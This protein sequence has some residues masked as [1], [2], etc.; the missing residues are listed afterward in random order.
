MH[1]WNNDERMMIACC[2]DGTRPV[3]F[4][5]ER[6][7]I[8]ETKEEKQCLAKQNIK[9]TADDAYTGLAKAKLIAIGQVFRF[10][11]ECCYLH[12]LSAHR[13]YKILQIQASF[14]I[15]ILSDTKSYQRWT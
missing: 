12:P 11:M 2:N 13:M 3:I 15:L 6:I 1:N 4:K 5:I 7:N 8:P 14:A 10:V 9:N